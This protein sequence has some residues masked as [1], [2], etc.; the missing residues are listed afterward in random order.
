MSQTK[1]PLETEVKV[2]KNPK[3]LKKKTDESTAS[4]ASSLP[5]SNELAMS[6]STEVT[7]STNVTA[8]KSTD[9]M[10]KNVII[11][12]G[13]GASGYILYNLYSSSTKKA[14]L[15]PELKLD[16]PTNPVQATCSEIK[17]ETTTKKNKN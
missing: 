8:N 6:P 1:A 12:V 15:K 17:L 16:A 10:W 2:K 9:Q 4:Q 13:L 14:M 5:T 7:S 3:F 11:G